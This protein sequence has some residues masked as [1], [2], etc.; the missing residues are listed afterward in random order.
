M[1]ITVAKRPFGKHDT[2]ETCH[3]ASKYRIKT[4]QEALQA[5]FKTKSKIVYIMYAPNAAKESFSAPSGHEAN[6]Y[7]APSEKVGCEVPA[8]KKPKLAG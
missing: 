2:Q 5:T 1:Q 3:P 7:F 8:K 6:Y 4:L